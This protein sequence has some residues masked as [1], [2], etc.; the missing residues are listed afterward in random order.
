MDLAAIFGAGSEE[1]L[2]DIFSEYFKAIKIYRDQKAQAEF[3]ASSLAKFENILEFVNRN[4][5]NP[6]LNLNM[7][8]ENF[9]MNSSSF[10][11]LFKKR[12][13]VGYLD[14]VHTKR[15]ERAVKLLKETSWTNQKIAQECGY[16]NDIAMIRSFQKYYHTSPG[17]IRNEYQKKIDF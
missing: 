12:M 7:I 1:E 4:L 5:Y 14:Y 15:L 11:K 6:N 8:E 17:K 16:L 9:S 13:S 10:S 2:K 3:Q